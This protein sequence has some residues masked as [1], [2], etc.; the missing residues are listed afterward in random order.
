MPSRPARPWTGTMSSGWARQKPGDAD[1]IRQLKIVSAIGAA[2]RTQAP[3]G[4]LGGAVRWRRVS[5]S[6][7]PSLSRSLRWRSWALLPRSPGSRG[8]H[9]RQRP[10]LRLGGGLVLLAGGGRDRRLLV[11]GRIVPLDLLRFR[12]LVDTAAWSRPRRLTLAALLRPLLP[13]AFLS[14]DA[15]AFCPRVSLSTPRRPGERRVCERL[16]E[17]CRSQSAWC[18]SRLTAAG[19]FGDFD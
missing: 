17:H 19:R 2:R 10:D 5:P 1:L 7:S 14:L 13:E 12:A 11:V 15:V 6:C 9:I 18:C 3:L 8:L 4:R 16:R